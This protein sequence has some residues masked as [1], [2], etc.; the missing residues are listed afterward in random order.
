[1]EY[2]GVGKTERWLSG[3]GQSNLL[4]C[5]CR[6]SNKISAY[7]LQMGRFMMKAKKFLYMDFSE[8]GSKSLAD[9]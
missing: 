7:E 4:Y 5:T 3:F 6:L 2:E 9:C 1:M 8:K